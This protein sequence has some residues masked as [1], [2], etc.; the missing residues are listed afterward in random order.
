MG[1]Q[2]GTTAGRGIMEDQRRG[3]LGQAMDL[4]ALKW[5]SL[6]IMVQQ[7][8]HRREGVSAPL[9]KVSPRSNQGYKEEEEAVMMYL[10]THLALAAVDP[11][12]KEWTLGVGLS[13]VH[14]GAL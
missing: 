12:K 11:G 13:E 4:N 3:L 8:G 10:Q 14:A 2:T 7:A 6:L 1:F 5:L 9:R